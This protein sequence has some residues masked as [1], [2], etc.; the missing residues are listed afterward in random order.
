MGGDVHSIHEFPKKLVDRSRYVECQV[1]SL[2]IKAISIHCISIKPDV[3]SSLDY[4]FMSKG[5]FIDPMTMTSVNS[6]NEWMNAMYGKHIYTRGLMN[7]MAS[8]LE[9]IR[10]YLAIPNRHTTQ[11]CKAYTGSKHCLDKWI[12]RHRGLSFSEASEYS[13]L[14]LNDPCDDCLPHLNHYQSLVQVPI[15]HLKDKSNLWASIKT[16][17]LHFINTKVDYTY[18]N[19]YYQLLASNIY[20]ENFYNVEM[21]QSDLDEIKE[22][23]VSK[24]ANSNSCIRTSRDTFNPEEAFLE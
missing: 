10:S 9:V 23:P 5:I 1:H 19:P 12:D 8:K 21:T 3:F 24:Y 16:T 4:D 22:T 13:E 7:E 14:L 11:M 2:I 20:E 18:G 6:E 17:L 15:L